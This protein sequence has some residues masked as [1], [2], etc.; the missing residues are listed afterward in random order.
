MISL[1]LSI[2]PEHSSKVI[3]TKL[4][5]NPK[6]TKTSLI[7]SAFNI[8]HLQNWMFEMYKF[9]VIEFLVLDVLILDFLILLLNI[10][11]WWFNWSPFW[12]SHSSNIKQGSSEKQVIASYS[13][14]E[15]IILCFESTTERGD[16]LRR[17]RKLIS[18]ELLIDLFISWHPIASVN[19]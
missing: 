11:S 3:I 19:N 7:I 6:V 16:K 15:K 1:T 2:S 4:W 13:P 12:I 10:L 8:F 18:F 5:A 17:D 14:V 9:L